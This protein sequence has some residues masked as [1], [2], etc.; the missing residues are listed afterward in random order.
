MCSTIKTAFIKSSFWEFWLILSKQHGLLANLPTH[1]KD[2]RLFLA[3]A[4]LFVSTLA[5]PSANTLAN[6][7]SCQ[8]L[9]FYECVDR[10]SPFVSKPTEFFSRL[11]TGF[12][13][14]KPVEKITENTKKRLYITE[15]PNDAFAKKSKYSFGTG[16]GFYTGGFRF[17]DLLV[18]S[19]SPN[20][21]DWI[22]SQNVG[23]V[24]SLE[25]YTA[26][27]IHLQIDPDNP[28]PN[29]R[30]YAGLFYIGAVYELINKRANRKGFSFFP[31]DYIARLELDY[32]L[33]GPY[34]PA[35][36]AQIAIHDTFSDGSRTPQGWNTQ[37]AAPGGFNLKLQFARSLLGWELSNRRSAFNMMIEAKVRHGGVFR[38]YGLGL[39]N[40]LT[41][42]SRDGGD[43]R[44]GFLDTFAAN[45]IGGSRNENDAACALIVFWNGFKKFVQHNT[46]LEGGLDDNVS[47]HTVKA[48]KWVWESQ[49]GWTLKHGKF[50]LSYSKTHRSS[51]IDHP[52][53]T[54]APGHDYGTVTFAY[55][56][57]YK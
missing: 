49:L 45:H 22:V 41:L 12:S 37:I 28:P 1:V 38:D 8:N 3:V 4:V 14:N 54:D 57:P 55:E 13:T 39:R 11:V 47:P 18:G 15:I 7:T 9:P 19:D 42:W 20:D 5:F 24:V 43:S 51:E 36:A 26:S 31:K 50:A 29:E 32:M 35:G 46:L 52:Q 6:E 53:A 56:Q 44:D 48:K 30:P 23:T 40:Y 10:F 16:D 34:S 25:V 21:S 17:H 33:L 27:D 2:P